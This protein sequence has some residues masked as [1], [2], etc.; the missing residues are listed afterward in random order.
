MLDEKQRSGRSISLGSTV[1]F[2]QAAKAK[3]KAKAKAEAKAE[4]KA[5]KAKAEPPPVV[6]VVDEGYPCRV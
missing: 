5:V 3:A 2:C 1:S 4:A 6:K